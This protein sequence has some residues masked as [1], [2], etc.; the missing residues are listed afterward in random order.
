MSTQDTN[1]FTRAEWSEC[2]ELVKQRDKDA[3]A[4]IFNHFS[5]RLKQFA[6]KHMGNEQVSIEL[7]QETMATV[8][9]KC[10]LFDGT[11]S[12]LSTWIYTI[13]RNQCFD[14]LRKQK[15]R[16]A[17][18]LADDI[19]PSDFLPPDLV[20]HYAPE[21]EMLKEQVLKFLDILPEAQRKV[22]QAVYLEEL[23]H[24]QVADMFDIPLGTVKSRLRLA[25]EKLRNEIEAEQL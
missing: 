20:E 24:Q 25:V 19:W 9:Q 6:Y 4:L 16:D 2:M 10:A 14:L 11:K 3:F 7:V 21:H 13:A 17:H 8:W 15:G 23:P 18:V 12:S 5:P 1:T 22:V